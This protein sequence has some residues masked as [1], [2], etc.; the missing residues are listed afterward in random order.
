MLLDVTPLSFGIETAGGVMTKIVSRGTTI[1]SKK[2]Q[3]FST[4]A[5]NQ[6]GTSSVSIL[7][8]Y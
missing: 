5:D 3:V 1:P 2:T 6:P 7:E 8:L 4:Y